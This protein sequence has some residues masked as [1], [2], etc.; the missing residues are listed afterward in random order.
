MIHVRTF[1]THADYEAFINA[2]NVPM[3][4]VS[5]CEGQ[6]EVHYLDNGTID[7]VHYDGSSVDTGYKLKIWTEPEN[8][9]IDPIDDGGDVLNSVGNDTRGIKSGK[10]V[11]ARKSFIDLLSGKSGKK[12]GSTWDYELHEVITFD[13]VDDL[14]DYLFPYPDDSSCWYQYGIGAGKVEGSQTEI[15]EN[16]IDMVTLAEEYDWNEPTDFEFLDVYSDQNYGAES[17]ND[18]DFSGW[19]SV[20]STI[21]DD[22][23]AYIEQNKELNVL[24]Y[25]ECETQQ[26]DL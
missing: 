9:E 12:V 4:N 11:A 16:F 23:A 1:E 10:R 25:M 5:I 6:V 8:D 22:I 24:R 17:I 19:F 26:E 18:C 2:G 14:M 7:K 3:P 15:E 20:V 21:L 13:T